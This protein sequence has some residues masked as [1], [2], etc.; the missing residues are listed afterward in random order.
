MAD[1]NESAR[2]RA[3]TG[4]RWKALMNNNIAQLLEYHFDTVFAPPT[5]SRNCAN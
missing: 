2:P 1:C 3:A 5:A 4:K